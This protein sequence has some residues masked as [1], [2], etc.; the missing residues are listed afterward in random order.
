MID[1]GQDLNQETFPQS[2]GGRCGAAWESLVSRFV[3]VARKYDLAN[4]VHASCT[5]IG[6]SDSALNRE[7]DRQKYRKEKE[8]KKCIDESH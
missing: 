6:L 1:K 4:I 3:N 7:K 2:I 5:A 8:C